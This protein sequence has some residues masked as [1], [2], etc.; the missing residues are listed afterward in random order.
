VIGFFMDSRC[1]LPRIGSCSCV[2]MLKKE[3]KS[4]LA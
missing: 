4:H 1:D 2:V 3:E